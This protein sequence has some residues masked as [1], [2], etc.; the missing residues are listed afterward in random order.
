MKVDC[1]TNVIGLDTSNFCLVED[2]VAQ[3]C[4]A[5]IIFPWELFYFKKRLIFFIYLLFSNRFTLIAGQSDSLMM[6]CSGI[7][8]RRMDASMHYELRWMKLTRAE[9]KMRKSVSKLRKK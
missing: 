1:D 2:G 3:V 8:G 9:W 7:I 4:F 5:S 6:N